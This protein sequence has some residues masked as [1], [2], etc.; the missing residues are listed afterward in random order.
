MVAGQR[1]AVGVAALKM[2]RVQGRAGSGGLGGSAAAEKGGVCHNLAPAGCECGEVGAVVE[3]HCSQS[4]GCH[5][6]PRED[7]KTAAA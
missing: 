2:E 5:L 6:L 4:I 3:A 7:H 1:R